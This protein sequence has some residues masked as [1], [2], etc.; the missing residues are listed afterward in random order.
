M[1]ELYPTYPIRTGKTDGNGA[2]AEAQN[3]RATYI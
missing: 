3:L 2:S 1:L